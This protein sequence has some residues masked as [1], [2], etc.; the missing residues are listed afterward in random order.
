MPN[1]APVAKCELITLLKEVDKLDVHLSKT[2][3]HL[4]RKRFKCLALSNKLLCLTD[5]IAKRVFAVAPHKATAFPNHTFRETSK[6][7]THHVF[8]LRNVQSFPRCHY[9]LSK[10]L[11]AFKLPITLV[12]VIYYPRPYIFD[13]IQ[14]Q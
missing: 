4:S 6:N 12:D 5:T 8:Q 2:F 10:I 3:A 14:V 9:R 7:P 13:D 11:N 1:P